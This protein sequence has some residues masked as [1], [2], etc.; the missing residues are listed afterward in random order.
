MAGRHYGQII[1]CVPCFQILIACVLTLSVLSPFF[2]T[3]CMADKGLM[4]FFE[5]NLC[6]R[7]RAHNTERVNKNSKQNI[8]EVFLEAPYIASILNDNSNRVHVC[9]DK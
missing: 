3:G 9:A 7:V 4:R 1:S 5:C 8:K 6:T 2:Q